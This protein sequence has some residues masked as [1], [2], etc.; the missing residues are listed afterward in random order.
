MTTVGKQTEKYI[1]THKIHQR[2]TNMGPTLGQ[3]KKE[4]ACGN[5]HNRTHARK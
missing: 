4:N 1:E 3:K 2:P 5:D